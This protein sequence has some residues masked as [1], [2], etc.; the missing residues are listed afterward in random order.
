MTQWKLRSR[1]AP[2]GKLLKKHSKKKKFQR[3][4]DY[5]PAH[6]GETK[7]VQIRTRGGSVKSVALSINAANV[8]SKD[9]IRKAKIITVLENTANPQFVRRNI[10]TKGAVIQTELGKARV[11]SKPGQS[12]VVD[13]VLIEEK[14]AKSA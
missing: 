6:M 13:A 10:I 5:L 2:T 11:T 7:R 4:R 8:V 14:A 12:G 1:R 3:S 9:G